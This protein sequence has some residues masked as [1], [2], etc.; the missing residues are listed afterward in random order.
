MKISN[1]NE[2]ISILQLVS[3]G[4]RSVTSLQNDKTL[5][6]DRDTLHIGLEQLTKLGLIDRTMKKSGDHFTIYHKITDNGTAVLQD[7]IPFK[8]LVSLLK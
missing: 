3:D 7:N 6:I 5:D 4:E 8:E 2:S 1:E